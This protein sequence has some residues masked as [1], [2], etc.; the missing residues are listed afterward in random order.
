MK[1]ISYIPKFDFL[2]YANTIANYDHKK[3]KIER[4]IRSKTSKMTKD[5]IKDHEQFFEEAKAFR[6]NLSFMHKNTLNLFF[7]QIEIIVD[8]MMYLIFTTGSYDEM[9]ITTFKKFLEKMCEKNN[10][11]LPEGYEETLE[12]VQ[13]HYASPESDVDIERTARLIIDIIK[14][15]SILEG[16]VFHSINNLFETFYEEKVVPKMNDIESIISRHQKILDQHPN[17]FIKE[18]TNGHLDPT[19]VNTTDMDPILAYFS[20]YSLFI[21][22]THKK[23]VY[24]MSLEKAAQDEEP[25]VMIQPLLKFL[26]DPKRYQMIQMLSKK[27]WYA[28]E[29]AKE[30]NITAA[31]MSYHINKLYGLGVIHFEQGDQN[32]L[33][34][35]LDKKRLQELMIQMQEDLLK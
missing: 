22:I 19:E 1:K 25:E 10:Y 17:D 3:E 21:S 7:H 6:D 35:E 5:V 24:G 13:E 18:L 4:E 29:L 2:Y 34:I 28:N 20:P 30:F 23:Y 15:P 32:R 12:V 8:Y 11:K 26:S 9:N 14:D 27:K 16:S 33:Y 31:T